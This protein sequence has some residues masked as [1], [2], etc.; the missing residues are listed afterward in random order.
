MSRKNQIAAATAITGLIV[1][2]YGTIN[3]GDWKIGTIGAMLCV[4]AALYAE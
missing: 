2:L 4:I 1:F 3:S